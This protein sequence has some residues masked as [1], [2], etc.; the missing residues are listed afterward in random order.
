MWMRR[1]R[2]PLLS[3]KN[4]STFIGMTRPTP[5]KWITA[6]RFPNV[7]SMQSWSAVRK[8]YMKTAPLR[9]GVSRRPFW[10]KSLRS[11]ASNNALYHSLSCR[12]F[13]LRAVC[14][15]LRASP[16][17]RSKAISNARRN[18]FRCD[19]CVWMNS[20]RGLALW[21]WAISPIVR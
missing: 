9:T 17:R 5:T 20:M 14:L 3:W 19:G 7:S 4:S 2:I 13:F 18:G 12:A 21:R 8:A 16:P 6:I 1:R 11:D 10:T 15:T